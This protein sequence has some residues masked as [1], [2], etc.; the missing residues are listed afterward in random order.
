M[1]LLLFV[2]GICFVMHYLAHDANTFKA[3]GA[4][5][6]GWQH[7]FL[8]KLAL[9]LGYMYWSPITRRPVVED[10]RAKVLKEPVG[11]LISDF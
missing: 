5:M 11:D 9:Q 7:S 1:Y 3:C 4:M 10:F 6:S 2:F 8:L